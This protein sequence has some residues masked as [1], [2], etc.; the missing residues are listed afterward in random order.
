MIRFCPN[1]HFLY[2]EYPFLDRFAAASDAGWT[3]VEMTFPY[4]VPAARIRAAADRAE[5]TIVEFNAPAGSIVRGERRG[6]AAVPGCEAEYLAQIRVGIAY[7]RELG[8]RLLLSLAGVVRPGDSRDAATRTFVDNLRAA[9]DICGEAGIV[10]LIETNNLRDNPHYYLR[11]VADARAVVEEVR[12]PNLRVVFDFYH[13]QI[14]EGDVTRRYLEA[15]DLTEHVQIGNPPDRNEPGVGELDYG[16]IFRV[17]ERSGYRGWVGGEFF[18]ASGQ[19]AQSL[20][21]MKVLGVTPGSAD[22][23]NG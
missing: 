20:D 23:Q 16:H 18:P 15:L 4:D 6:L 17:I 2:R 9:A 19:T 13:V 21:R 22:A 5:V 12:H 11:T 8:C 10:L 1:L 3:G 7:A 14:N